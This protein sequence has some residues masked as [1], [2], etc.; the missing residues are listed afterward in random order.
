MGISAKVLDSTPAPILVS[1]LALL[2]VQEIRGC[3][4]FWTAR[5]DSFSCRLQRP[6]HCP[7]ISDEELSE[8]EFRFLVSGRLA[9]RE[10]WVALS[11][12][13]CSVAWIRELCQARL[14]V[15]A[16]AAV[17]LS[18]C[19]T[20]QSDRQ[21]DA[22]GPRDGSWSRLECLGAAFESGRQRRDCDP[23]DHFVGW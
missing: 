7:F 13:C 12:S 5:C 8:W 6:G 14:E 15:P 11:R 9:G 20:R 10:I 4:R 16:A 1:V 22:T 21:T 23:R 19:S 17:G 18:F 2:S 3:R